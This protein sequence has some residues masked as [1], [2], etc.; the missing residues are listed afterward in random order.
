MRRRRKERIERRGERRHRR[1]IKN[2]LGQ[3]KSCQRRRT[4]R[5]RSNG[6]GVTGKS[7]ERRVYITAEAQAVGRASC[8]VERVSGSRSHVLAPEG[9][10]AR[11]A[12]AARRVLG[13]L[14][15]SLP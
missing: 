9:Q 11:A 4:Q 5:R 15:L 1:S 10:T 14:Q 2:N 7:T 8:E 13:D 12:R 6:K 3:K